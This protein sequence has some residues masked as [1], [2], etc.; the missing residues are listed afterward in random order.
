MEVTDGST[1]VKTEGYTAIEIEEPKIR[2]WLMPLHYFYQKRGLDLP[3]LTFLDGATMPDP[4][5]TLL[6]HDDDMTPTLARHHGEA[7]G[8]R[9]LGCERSDDYL[10]RM[11]VLETIGTRV[12]VEYGA[13]GIDLGRFEADV[14]RLIVEGVEPLGGILGERA[15]PHV[16]QP[17][18]FF[19]I[20]CDSLVSE[21]LDM[22][23][24]SELFGRCN[25]LSDAEGLVFA[26]IVEILPE[27][28]GAERG[29][30]A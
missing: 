20:S 28:G 5:R 1:L 24:G 15:V 3:P 13:I 30:G 25:Q 22:V 17:R 11:V 19:A 26:D 9:V 16:S 18:G 29:V 2:H 23:A 12:P 27:Q 14:Q 10:L 21:A 4:E 7:L 6:V 8:L